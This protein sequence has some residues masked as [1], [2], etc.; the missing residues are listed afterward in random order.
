MQ[1]GMAARMGR[2]GS[3]VRADRPVVVV[4]AGV[5][6]LSVAAQLAPMVPVLVADRLPATGG[7]LG[8]QHPVVAALAAECESAGVVFVL[9]TTAVRRD[10]ARVLLAGPEGVRWTEH[11]HLVYAGGSR[12]STQAELGIAGERLAGVFPAPV[13]IHLMEA[14]VRL[15]HNAVVLGTGDWSQRV[16]EEMMRQ[17]VKVTLPSVRLPG[18]TPTRV[19]GDRRVEALTLVNADRE[20]TIECD[21]VILAGQARPV[22]NVDGAIRPSPGVSYVQPIAET[23]RVH[24]VMTYARECAKSL[25]HELQGVRL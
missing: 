11:C 6:G 4:G 19:C 24:A 16:V 7:V 13:A 3:V 20:Q 15:G 21:A 8:Y 5:S 10:N 12:P 2:W 17:G 9:G 22:R 25:A 23:Q 1:S 18:W 14:D